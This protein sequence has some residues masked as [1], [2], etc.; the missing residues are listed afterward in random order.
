[1]SRTSPED[2]RHRG[3]ATEV[4]A[5]PRFRSSR[6]RRLTLTIVDSV[7]RFRVGGCRI[8]PSQF[9][10]RSNL[11]E[12]SSQHSGI[13]MLAVEPIGAGALTALSKAA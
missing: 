3:R 2:V 7:A 10:H 13:P 9:R 6:F 4:V 11:L 5:A 1:M 8:R 12:T